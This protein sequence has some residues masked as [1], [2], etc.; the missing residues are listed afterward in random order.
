MF[1][2][3]IMM[4]NRF[5]TG[6]LTLP[7]R[8][9]LDQ[10]YNLITMII[11]KFIALI[12]AILISTCTT[13]ASNLSHHH[14]R[15]DDRNLCSGVVSQSVVVIGDVRGATLDL[16]VPSDISSFPV[17][18]QPTSPKS[19][20]EARGPSQS[21]PF[22]RRQTLIGQVYLCTLFNYAGCSNINVYAG[23]GS[24]CITKFGVAS[25]EMPTGYSCVMWDRP[26]CV[27]NLF[28]TG[29]DLPRLDSVGWLGRAKRFSCVGK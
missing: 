9:P 5:S 27:G 17:Q 7:S 25:L 3:L 20:L 24:G 23:T 28:V 6:N 26:G 16:G 2:Y 4:Q 11:M 22:T 13:L 21:P 1:V 29:V 12:V 18:I 10:H 15:S 14:L 19:D 8:L